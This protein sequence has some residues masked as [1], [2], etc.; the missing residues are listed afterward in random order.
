MKQL[1]F[2]KKI[3]TKFKTKT[4]NMKSTIVEDDIMDTGAFDATFDRSSLR[5]ARTSMKTMSPKSKRKIMFRR[6]Q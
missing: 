1:K 3:R 4:M 6:I 5:R 2:K